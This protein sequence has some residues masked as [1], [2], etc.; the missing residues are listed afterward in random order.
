M[1]ARRLP[2]GNLRVPHFVRG[3]NGECGTTY[4]ELTPAD[5]EYESWLPF[6]LDE[7]PPRRDP[8]KPLG[9]S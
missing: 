7:L 1:I 6:V 3:P 9:E 8:D 4:R 2:N 5:P